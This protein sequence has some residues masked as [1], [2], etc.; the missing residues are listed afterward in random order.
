MARMTP[1]PVHVLLDDLFFRS[2]IEATA[3][4]AGVPL[5]VSRA[6]PQLVGRIDAEGGRGVL[7]DLALDVAIEAIATL[8]RRAE[9]VVVVAWGSHVDQPVMDAARGAGAD[10]VLP[11]S[12]FTRR[13][14]E[15]LRELSD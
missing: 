3:E 7:I 9:P 11:K 5:Y 14:P 15:I 13:L 4:A 1:S 6:L 12:A 8:K 2:R 10:R